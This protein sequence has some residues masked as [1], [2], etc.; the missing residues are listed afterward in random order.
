MRVKAPTPVAEPTGFSP[1]DMVDSQTAMIGLIA[2]VIRQV[3]QFTR[4]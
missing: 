2:L 1:A 4:R 3:L